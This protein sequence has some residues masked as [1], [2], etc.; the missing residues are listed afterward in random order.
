MP[1]TEKQ[2]NIVRNISLQP[3]FKLVEL[4]SDLLETIDK[5]PTEPVYFKATTTQ[6]DVVICSSSKT[7]KLR[8]RNHSNT[9][10]MTHE[11]STALCVKSG[12]SE[13]DKDHDV[14]CGYT[15]LDSVF[16]CH[17]TDGEIDIAGLPLY[18]GEHSLAHFEESK[19]SY[20]FLSVEE[21]KESSAISE[22]EFA[23]L[24]IKMNGSSIN[25]MAVILTDDFIT[26]GLH[27]ILMSLMAAQV[28]LSEVSIIECY[29]LV[30]DNNDF[31]MD[32]VETI[33]KK[34]SKT[35][36]EPLEF[37]NVKVAKWY[38]VEALRKFATR[39]AIHLDDF[40]MKWKTEFPPFFE[41]PIDIPLLKGQYVSPVKDTVLYLSKDS[42]PNEVQ[43]RL[44]VLFKHQAVWDIE[45]IIP[46]VEEFNVKKLK[47]DSF[48]MKFAR[49]KK[50]GKTVV[51]TQR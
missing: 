4:P 30:N 12:I 1:A 18:D 47:F 44:K 38:G 6:D 10:L 21:L 16:E 3:N 49:K 23:D 9:V 26:R 20:R 15:A 2:F 34:F 28:D 17:Q 29:N 11:I 42:L 43:A 22:A 50:I 27:V 5:T 35:K 32:I 48:I 8:Q 14:M 31:S 33:L 46:F 39:S 19:S 13:K 7:Y 41:C 37:D 45:D 36:Q 51:V 25:D 24:W 40:L